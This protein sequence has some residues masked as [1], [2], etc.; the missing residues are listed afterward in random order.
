MATRLTSVQTTCL[1]LVPTNYN[2]SQTNTPITIVYYV[3]TNDISFLRQIARDAN[4]RD[5]IEAQTIVIGRHQRQ[6]RG[7]N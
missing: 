6:P 2:R 5:D 1:T 3:K 4:H 7:L